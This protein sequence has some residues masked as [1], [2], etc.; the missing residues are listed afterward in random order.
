MSPNASPSS[1]TSSTATGPG[2]R[3]SAAQ[4][5]GVTF[6]GILAAVIVTLGAYCLIR[7]NKNQGED[8]NSVET[9][10]NS[11]S[12]EPWRILEG[13]APAEGD[14]MKIPRH[15]LTTISEREESAV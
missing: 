9:W 7:A 2:P 15:S 6:A 5:A 8:D 12:E 13:T 1:I 4:T 10:G 3:W 11:A 14:S